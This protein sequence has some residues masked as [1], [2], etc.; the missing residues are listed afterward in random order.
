MRPDTLSTA[1]P[2]RTSPSRRRKLAAPAGA[3]ALFGFIGRS[4]AGKTTIIA[5]VIECLRMDGFTVSAIKRAHDGFDLDRPGKDSWRLRE[6]GCEEVMLVGD[7]R[8]ALLHE[9][10]DATEPSPREIASRMREVD[11]IL[12]EGFRSAPIPMIEVYRPALGKPWLW[13]DSPSEIAVASDEEIECAL[14]VLA[15]SNRRL[16]CDFLTAHLRLRAAAG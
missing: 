10:R 3:P 8:W 4:G 6:S 15:L 14:P 9:Y 7:E 11:I 13:P 16:V 1:A 12:F 2:A 5:Q